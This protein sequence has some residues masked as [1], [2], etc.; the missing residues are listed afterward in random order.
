MTFYASITDDQA[1]ATWRKILARSERIPVVSPRAVIANLPGLGATACY[2][3]DLP[4]LTPDERSRLVD[5]LAASFGLPIQ[6][7]ADDIDEHGVPIRASTC[8][9]VMQGQADE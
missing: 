3:L 6:E 8:V 9:I 1:A 4:R 2:F 5:H 7:V